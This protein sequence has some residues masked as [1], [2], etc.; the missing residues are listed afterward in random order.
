[1]HGRLVRQWSS[2][3]VT[4][5]S[6]HACSRCSIPHCR[7]RDL[8][9]GQSAQ[10][11]H[12]SLNLAW[13]APESAACSTCQPACRWTQNWACSARLTTRKPALARD[14]HPQRNQ[15]HHSALVTRQSRKP[16]ASRVLWARHRTVPALGPSAQ[17]QKAFLQLYNLCRYNTADNGAKRR[18]D[19]LSGCRLGHPVSASAARLQP[20]KFEPATRP[21]LAPEPPPDA[22]SPAASLVSLTSTAV[23]SALCG[24]VRA[25]ESPNIPVSRP[26]QQHAALYWGDLS[27]LHEGSYKAVVLAISP[28]MQA[29]FSPCSV[30]TAGVLRPT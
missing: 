6:I 19:G 4:W 22:S 18:P 14:Q 27:M 29:A 23:R 5:Y 12:Q 15:T 16:W 3:N 24:K 28:D 20:P 10:V 25:G 26:T 1:M 2:D 11:L 7:P 13:Q 21:R 9:C 8:G 17:G 30:L